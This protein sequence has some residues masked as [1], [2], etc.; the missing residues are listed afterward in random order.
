MSFVRKLISG[1]KIKE[2][3]RRLA[4]S[5]SVETY[6]ALA[7]AH[8]RDGD[9]DEAVRVC[10]EGIESYGNDPE[11]V[12][13]HHRTRELRLEDRTRELSRQLAEAPRS[14]V[15]KELC[16]NLLAGG[17]HERAE[18]L[19]LEWY[20]ALQEGAAQL[21]RARARLERFFA[22]R[23]S[24]DGRVALEL[25]AEAER[26]MPG[27]PEPLELRLELYTRI[28]AW[29]E[30]HTLVAR[31]LERNPGDPHLEERY[32][33]LGTMMDNSPT[34]DRALRT[35][36]KTGRLMDEEQ[37]GA[38][39][40][41]IDSRSIRPR[42]REL[43]ALEGVHAAI[44]TR[45]STALVQGP[46]GATAE[47]TARAAREVVTRSRAAA[48]RLGLGQAHEIEIEG[49]FGH[50]VAVPGALGAAAIWSNAPLRDRERRALAAL[51]SLEGRAQTEDEG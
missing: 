3:R 13:L 16:E 27:D 11:L 6:A 36:E 10:E 5:P 30:A 34:V 37:G 20:Q 26:L 28:G 51:A 25:V 39:N 44:Y 40:A 29:A 35:V 7:A 46:K 22:G 14:A 15:Y 32:R 38:G 48:R 47:R 49:D 23:G 50:L 4:E 41:A 45:G 31:L 33:T 21:M 43:Q 1:S 8:A 18:K 17:R 42:L 12:R 19:A 24:E 2:A 9:F